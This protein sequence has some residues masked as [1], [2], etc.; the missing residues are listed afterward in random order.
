MLRILCSAFFFD[1]LLGMQNYFM[2]DANNT[3]PLRIHVLKFYSG[4]GQEV[5]YFGTHNY[6]MEFKTTQIAR[7][8]IFSRRISHHNLLKGHFQNRIRVFAVLYFRVRTFLH[9]VKN[10]ST[11]ISSVSRL[12]G[13]IRDRCRSVDFGASL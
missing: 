8:D 2:S 7:K 1:W 12:Q 5:K 10:V 13:G 3:I 9:F 6:Y 11:T 4:M